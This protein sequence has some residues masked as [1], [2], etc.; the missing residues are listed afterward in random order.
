MLLHHFFL[1][2]LITILLVDK[3]VLI[4]L[5]HWD[6]NKPNKPHLVQPPHLL[7]FIEFSNP[8]FN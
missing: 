8:P 6:Q 4:H 3:W 2:L 7:Y 5:R 1:L